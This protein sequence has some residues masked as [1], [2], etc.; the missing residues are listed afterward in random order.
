VLGVA[1]EPGEGH[2][3]VSR[4]RQPVAAAHDQIVV[5]AE[6]RVVAAFLR[7]AR[8]REQIVVGSALLGLGEH[9]VIH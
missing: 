6:E 1:C 3:G 5:G 2:P 8:D 9:S 7:L 4:S